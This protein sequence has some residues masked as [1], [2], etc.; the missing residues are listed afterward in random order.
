MEFYKSFPQYSISD[1]KPVAG[2]FVF[3]VF[4]DY[5]ERLI[6][7][8]PLSAWYIDQENVVIFLPSDD[9]SL[10]DWDWIGIYKVS[11]RF[12]SNSCL[13]LLKLAFIPGRFLI[14]R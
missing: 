1:H 12:L 14:S 5:S 8:E 4:R 11:P 7:F 10:S 13:K 2:E 3:K 9:V 6:E